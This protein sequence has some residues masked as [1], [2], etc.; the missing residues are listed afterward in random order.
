MAEQITNDTGEVLN[1]T[2]AKLT[3]I[4][5]SASDTSTYTRGFVLYVGTGGDVKV[6][7]LR[8]GTVT[9]KNVPDGYTLP[10]LL[11]KVYSSGTTASDL[12]IGE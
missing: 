5:V 7:G 2:P 11:S 10:F 9:L 4:D 8:D 12:V 3:S 6:D 1:L